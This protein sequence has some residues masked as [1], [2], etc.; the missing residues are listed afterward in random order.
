MPASRAFGATRSAQNVAASDFLGSSAT[1]GRPVAVGVT[2]ARSPV[3]RVTL[4]AR[5]GLPL[6]APA[7]DSGAGNGAAWPGATGTAGSA[8]APGSGTTAR[9]V[10]VA[11]PAER[12]RV[13]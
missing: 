10:A 7:G 9:S 6:P 3:I 8:V 5:P 12:K 1:D 11:R 4:A 2:T 13:W